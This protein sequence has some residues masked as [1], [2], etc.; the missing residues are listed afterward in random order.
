MQLVA[1]ATIAETVGRIRSR[2]ARTTIKMAR[3][4]CRYKVGEKLKVGVTTTDGRRVSRHALR[5]GE[6][7]AD[8][9]VVLSVP[10]GGEHVEFPS[11]AGAAADLADRSQRPDAL[12]ELKLASGSTA[13][14]SDTYRLAV[15]AGA[16]AQTA[17]AAVTLGDAL[18]S[19][20][21]DPVRAWEASAAAAIAAAGADGAEA[22]PALGDARRAQ[23]LLAERAQAVHAARR[24]RAEA[25]EAESEK[26]R[27]AASDLHSRKVGRSAPV[28]PLG[29]DAD[30]EKATRRVEEL[31]DQLL[32]AEQAERAER[33][34]NAAEDAE[35][36]AS[37]LRRP[38]GIL[39]G[40]VD[41]LDPDRGN[42]YDQ[43][44]ER[45][46]EDSERGRGS[47]L[48]DP[49]VAELR[50]RLRAEESSLEQ[51]RTEAE[52]AVALDRREDFPSG[53]DEARYM[54]LLRQSFE[55]QD[56]A[57]AERAGMDKDLDAIRGALDRV[58]AAQQTLLRARPSAPAGRRGLRDRLR[59]R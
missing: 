22:T 13:R 36:L 10:L 50:Q 16:D 32:A 3:T 51:L 28:R 11:T 38:S 20:G 8:T 21:V 42:A 59:R 57:V 47:Y 44:L 34:R 54:A 33:R 4:A 25:L 58:S 49:R 45:V 48:R 31:R 14:A 35:A 1:S 53:A 9:P 43:L 27:N 37:A 6:L 2:R 29:H 41:L 18:A 12:S 39:G 23:A 55:L 24:A 40:L 52:R 5:S 30:I 19:A 17:A 26:L 15:A 46:R 56:A 7:D